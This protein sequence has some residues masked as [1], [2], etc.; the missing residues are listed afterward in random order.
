[1]RKAGKRILRLILMLLTVVVVLVLT[2]NFPVTNF[3]NVRSANDYSDWMEE[4][5]VSDQLVIDVAMLGAHDAF[6]ADMGLFSPVDNLSADS[7]QKGAVGLLIKGFSLRQSRTQVSSATTMLESGVRYFDVRLSFNN[8]ESAWYTSHTYFSADFAQILGEIKLFLDDHP[9]EFLILDLQHIYGADYENDEDLLEIHDLLQA[10]G[11][12]DYAYQEGS[13][14]LDEVTYGDVTGDKTH[15][16][17]IIVAKFIG[18]DVHIWNYASAIRS[19]WPNSDSESAVFSYLDAEASLIEAGEALTGNQMADNGDAIDSRN[20]F[21]VMQAVLT[22][23]MSGEGI[24]E[25]LKTWS[26]LERA[27]DFNCDLVANANFDTWLEAMPI[28][29]VD[30]A[31]TNQDGFLDDVMARIVDFDAN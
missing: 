27:K 11:I 23:Q 17:V 25:G 14:N 8:K 24:L 10:S 22:M 21:R 2:L 16:G 18:E 1:M 28:V 31:D 20:A 7:I 30:Y 3:Q 5:L 13:K 12:L 19:A 15:G 6:T 9:G 4:T 29:M 26:L